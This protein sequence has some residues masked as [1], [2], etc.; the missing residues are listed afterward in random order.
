[1]HVRD[2]PSLPK[3]RE[4]LRS[5]SVTVRF[6]LVIRVILFIGGEERPWWSST[7]LNEKEM[8]ENIEAFNFSIYVVENFKCF[9][10]RVEK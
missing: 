5:F 2:L 1:M 10:H 6:Y 8:M 9:L 3:R 7:A 4:L